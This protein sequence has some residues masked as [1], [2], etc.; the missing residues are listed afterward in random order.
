MSVSVHQNLSE[1]LLQS[2]ELRNALRMYG[3]AERRRTKLADSPAIYEIGKLF[4][5]LLSP[6]SFPNVAADE[7]RA[8][9]SV[10]QLLPSHL[11]VFTSEVVAEGRLDDGRSFVVM[12]RGSPL[13]DK[14]LV[15]ELQRHRIKPIVLEWLRGLVREAEAPTEATTAEFQSSLE[16]LARL[17]DIPTEISNAARDGLVRLSRGDFIPRHCPMHGDLWRG[18]IIYGRDKSLKVIDWRGSRMDGYGFF[19]L[20]K[21]G[22]SFKIKTEELRGEVVIHARSLGI[23]AIDA[24][25]TLLASCG[26]I[27]RNRGEFPL[28]NFLSM[29]NSLCNFLQSSL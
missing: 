9:K 23:E 20:V 8:I 12:P 19:D 24:R 2:S 6:L 27:S 21:F 26:F 25:T 28:D 7:A 22:H 16:S 11:S 3:I 17:N 4:I 14:R 29:T 1:R 15:F 18:N 13:S 5:V 10:R